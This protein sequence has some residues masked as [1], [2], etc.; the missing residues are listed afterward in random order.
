MFVVTR[1]HRQGLTIVWFYFGAARIRKYTC[2]V[3]YTE[4]QMYIHVVGNESNKKKK[5]LYVMGS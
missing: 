3:K 4:I 2:W 5:D 1:M